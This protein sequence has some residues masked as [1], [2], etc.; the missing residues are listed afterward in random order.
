[1]RPMFVNLDQL[2]F[3]AAFFQEGLSKEGA[4]LT[5]EDSNRDFFMRYLGWQNASL[6]QHCLPPPPK[7]QKK[8]IQLDPKIMTWP[9][10]SIQ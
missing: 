9:T 8:L 4:K 1:M 10:L 3:V 5:S 7:K 6:E 2:G